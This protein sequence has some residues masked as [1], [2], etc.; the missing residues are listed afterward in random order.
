M[1]PTH[2]VS[3]HGSIDEFVGIFEF[4]P[5]DDWLA[6]LGIVNAPDAIRPVKQVY[7]LLKKNH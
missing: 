7:Y 3:K 4:E 6:H 1:L 2:V 5:I